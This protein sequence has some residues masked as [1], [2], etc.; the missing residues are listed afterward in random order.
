MTVKALV[1]VEVAVGKVE[2]V[3]EAARKI[4]GVKAVDA[5]TGPYDLAVTVEAA[6]VGAIGTLVTKRIHTIPH[7]SKTTTC[8]IVKSL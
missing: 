6:E 8:V 4:E 7:V 5:V 2:E 3:A 1:L